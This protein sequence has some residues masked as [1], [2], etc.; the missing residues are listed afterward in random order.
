MHDDISMLAGLVLAIGAPEF[1]ARFLVALRSLCGARLCSAFS[2]AGVDA[3]QTLFAEG[4]CR[5]GPDFA[6][7]A[8][9]AYSRRYWRNDRAARLSMAGRGGV[10]VIR[11]RAGDIADAEY[12]STCYEQGGIA[13]RLS[14]LSPGPRP[15]VAN[16]YRAAGD[17]A[18]QPAEIARME[19][20]APVLMAALAR[21]VALSA[22]RPGDD[23]PSGVMQVLLAAGAGLSVREA[24]VA[25]G[26]V[27]GRTQAEIGMATGLTLS[28]V[29]TYRRRAYCKL[30]VMDK[31][32]LTAAYRE[33]A[34]R[35]L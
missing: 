31:R 8:S 26:L 13:E 27:L 6:R 7:M 28:S 34:V 30:G 20:Y 16:G 19:E 5:G 22:R 11:T 4:E 10:A 1:P 29:V 14:L 12:R 9:L 2:Y 3:P 35:R 18:F 32:E 17:G 21:H 25:A 24:E 23:S 33:L 15:L